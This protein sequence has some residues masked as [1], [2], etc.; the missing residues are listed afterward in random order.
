MYIA[1]QIDSFFLHVILISRIIRRIAR[2]PALVG[3]RV[4]YWNVW[5]L[6]LVTIHFASQRIRAANRQPKF[7]FRR[8]RCGAG[9]RTDRNL[10][11]GAGK[12]V[13]RIVFADLPN[14]NR[15][16]SSNLDPRLDSVFTAPG[17]CF[18]CV[19]HIGRTVPHRASPTPRYLYLAI[20]IR[21][22]L[23]FIHFPTFVAVPPLSFEKLM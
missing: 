3:S 19:A 2:G 18:D 7:Q 14:S 11:F 22:R 4:N 6:L 10:V 12:R 1:N 13:L 17:A 16:S 15:G 20:R 5:T 23:G 21:R 8:T 9:S